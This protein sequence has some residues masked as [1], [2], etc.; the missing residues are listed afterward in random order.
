MAGLGMVDVSHV[1]CHVGGLPLSKPDF[2]P[3]CSSG[4]V[5][6]SRNAASCICQ[7][8]Q[9]HQLANSQRRQF[10]GR[11]G[12]EEGKV[13]SECCALS[14]VRCRTCSSWY[15]S[16]RGRLNNDRFT[17]RDE[18]LG[19][20]DRGIWP[21]SGQCCIVSNFSKQCSSSRNSTNSRGRQSTKVRCKGE[22]ASI[23]GFGND[24]ATYNEAGEVRG[25]GG[26]DGAEGESASPIALENSPVNNSVDD[27]YAMIGVDEGLLKN[28]LIKTYEPLSWK[29]LGTFKY[30]MVT[31][32]EHP[33]Y[34]PTLLLLYVPFWCLRNPSKCLDALMSSNNH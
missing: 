7:T 12:R 25:Q 17:S 26:V 23:Y 22:S 29:L 5:F 21:L 19:R 9:S 3:R 1:A 15:L 10:W 13:N 27:G 11:I 31:F 20:R 4:Q 18:G 8:S 16:Q 24:T 33:S 32:I 30:H 6:A 28:L 2:R 34:S 14:R